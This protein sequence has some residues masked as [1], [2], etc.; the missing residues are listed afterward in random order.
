[1]PTIGGASG[2]NG[3]VIIESK[4]SESVPWLIGIAFG[5]PVVPLVKSTSASSSSFSTVSVCSRPPVTRSS[6]PSTTPSTACSSAARYGSP[7]TATAQQPAVRT[8]SWISV[9]FNC[10]FISAAAAPM[11]AA[12]RITTVDAR[13][14]TSTT[15]T[16][17]P[18]PTPRSAST[19]AQFDT[20]AA[21]SAYVNSSSPT[22][23]AVREGSCRDDRVEG[24][25]DVQCSGDQEEV[26]SS[27]LS[28]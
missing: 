19:A 20:A 24:V 3:A 9:G 22:I 12:P 10:T 2:S 14:P 16:R 11:R 26:R 27:L 13:P 7:A 21:T 5:S 23:S 1:M 8:S 18:G 4:R 15:A 28:H 6:G 25:R 17:S